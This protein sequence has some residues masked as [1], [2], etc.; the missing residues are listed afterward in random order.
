MAQE[1]VSAH[2]VGSEVEVFYDPANPRDALLSPKVDTR[3]VAMILVS[4][5]LTV[6]VWYTTFLMGVEFFQWF[7]SAQLAGG[8]KLIQERM[9]LRARLPQYQPSKIGL[10]ALCGTL[11]VGGFVLILAGSGYPPMKAGAFIAAISC[12][13]G[14][15]AFWWFYSGI[16]SG[17]T[18]LLIDE[19]A[20][21]MQ[22]PL[23]YKRRTRLTISFSEVKEVTL[24]KIAHR[25]R[26][27][28]TY[29]YAPTLQLL[30][31]SSQKLADFNQVKAE[32]FASWL[33][34]KINL[35]PANPITA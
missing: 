20:R 22:L 27:G 8:V 17:K 26:Y 2:P 12:I 23:T 16:A 10:F 25:G 4:L 9:L 14:A 24:E 33:R 30:D 5:P 13:A 7:R 34:E 32:A 19:V 31:G 6:L 3:D 21:T 28:V 29:T 18:D 15:V 35:Q 1:I 11:L